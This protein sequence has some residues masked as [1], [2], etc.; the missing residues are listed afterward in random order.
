[1]GMEKHP[2]IQYLS[3]SPA[4]VLAIFAAVVG[5]GLAA[6]V[7]SQPS[8]AQAD[9]PQGSLDAFAKCLTEK[10]AVMYGASWCSHCNEQK[11]MFGDS[12]QYVTFI[13]CEQSGELCNLAGISGYPTWIIKGQQHPGTQPLGQL[14]ALTGCPLG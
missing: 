1:M 10:G 13:D 3:K 4:I 8:A 12:F 9:Y 2:F 6:F 5:V 11:K 7:L 14:S